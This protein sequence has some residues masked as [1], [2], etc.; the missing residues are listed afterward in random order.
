MFCK[1]GWFILRGNIFLESYKLM[2]QGSPNELYIYIHINYL[3]LG[4]IKK[5]KRMVIFKD[6]PYSSALLG[7]VID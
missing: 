4:G 2:V 7:L 5:C 6:F 1:G 3:C